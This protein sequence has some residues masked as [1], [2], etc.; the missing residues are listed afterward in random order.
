MV[1]CHLALN[2]IKNYYKI[3][4]EQ[5]QFEKRIDEPEIQESEYIYDMACAAAHFAPGRTS[6]G[7]NI[8]DTLIEKNTPPYWIA[9]AYTCDDN[10]DRIN[11]WLERSFID[12]ETDE[13]TYIPVEPAFKKYHDLP[14]VKKIIRE[15]KYPD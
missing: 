4:L 14:A 9:F 12:R 2:E 11:D 1:I 7:Q 5:G 6:R 10:P 8:I 13:L 15:I 3:L